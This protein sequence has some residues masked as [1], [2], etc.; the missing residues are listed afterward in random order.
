MS[1]AAWLSADGC[2]SRWPEEHGSKCAGTPPPGRARWNRASFEGS[3]ARR[4]TPA[5][6][7]SWPAPAL[8]CEHGAG[9]KTVDHPVSGAESPDPLG[10]DDKTPPCLAARLRRGIGEPGADVALPLETI[11]GDVDRSAR[12]LHAAVRLDFIA[13]RDGIRAVPEPKDGEQDELF[14]FTEQVRHCLLS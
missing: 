4:A 3:I 12:K 13:D 5:R 7:F 2:R 11:Q 8:R 9:A 10:F 6:A 14:D 1:P